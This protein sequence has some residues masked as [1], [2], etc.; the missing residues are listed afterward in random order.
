[1]K[2][3]NLKTPWNLSYTIELASPKEGKAIMEQLNPVPLEAYKQ[4]FRHYTPYLLKDGRVA[5]PCE[6]DVT[7]YS[8][9]EGFLANLQTSGAFIQKHIPKTYPIKFIRHTLTGDKVIFYRISPE[10]FN[11]LQI[12]ASAEQVNNQQIW[13][14]PDGE[15]LTE[16]NSLFP[17]R[18]SFIALSQ[19]VTFCN[20]VAMKSK[21][22]TP[23]FY[24]P[25][26]VGRNPYGKE[27]LGHIPELI[28]KLPALLE[29]PEKLLSFKEHSLKKIEPYLYRQ[30]IT[31]D[32]AECV[33]LPLL[34]YIGEVAKKTQNGEWKVC[35]DQT[36]DQWYPDILIEEGY[37]CLHYPL[38]HILDNS[39]D[40]YYPLR[41][42]LNSKG[43]ESFPDASSL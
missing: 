20:I 11:S 17:D 31:A 10:E 18:A 41:I 30:L 7:F 9:M 22:E 29:L 2:A 25:E 19:H 38:H 12:A 26:F 16:G 4:Y 42:V 21:G 8:S 6:S 37:K 43:R 34:C 33:F 15:V 35:Y 1:M 23:P 13:I 39:K 5:L 14:T 27:V 3:I 40:T 28:E 36:L 24:A 32:F